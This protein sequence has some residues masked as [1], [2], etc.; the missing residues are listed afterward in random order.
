VTSLRSLNRTWEDAPAVRLSIGLTHALAH[1][2]HEAEVLKIRACDPRS[3]IR[4]PTNGHAVI[5][6]VMGWSAKRQRMAINDRI[7][8]AR[9][10]VDAAGRAWRR[11]R[12]LKERERAKI[13]ALRFRRR[14]RAANCDRAKAARSDGGPQPGLAQ[15]R[16]LVCAQSIMPKSTE[17]V[18]A[19]SAGDPSTVS[20]E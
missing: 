2:R 6:A 3:S 16:D 17:L 7:D 4:L 12:R 13:A 19:E 11:Y 8:A 14:R 15:F 18:L 20:C 5:L 9:E 10:R 1:P